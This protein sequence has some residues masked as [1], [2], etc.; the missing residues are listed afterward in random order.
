MRGGG[1][2]G[3]PG[4]QSC[5]WDDRQSCRWDGEGLGHNLDPCV[6]AVPCRACAAPC[7]HHGGGRGSTLLLTPNST[8]P[9][10]SRGPPRRLKGHSCPAAQRA[11]GCS[12]SSAPQLPARGTCSGAQQRSHRGRPQPDG[13][14]P[15]PP[16][17]HH[18]IVD[19]R[20]VTTPG[21]GCSPSSTSWPEVLQAMRASATAKN[22][23][24]QAA[25]PALLGPRA[26]LLL[27]GMPIG[28]AQA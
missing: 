28:R 2:Y 1:A 17:F 20:S 24:V 6:H 14:D 16:S 22:M 27:P 11:H 10:T 9:T 13:D 21:L 18:P 8:P 26:I 4:R 25:A 7:M 23:A 3:G 19:R 12:F 5:R 15:R